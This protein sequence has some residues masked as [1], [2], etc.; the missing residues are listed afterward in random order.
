MN[1]GTG[2]DRFCP[3]S[4]PW[5]ILFAMIAPLLLGLA[6]PGLVRARG[7]VPVAR[8][9]LKKIMTVD[10]YERA[11]LNRL[12]AVQRR[13]FEA[14]LAKH[15]QEMS[16]LIHPARVSPAP[17]GHQST[18]PSAP[19]RFGLPRH[20]RP[21]ISGNSMES[22]IEGIFRGWS[23]ATRF[24][25]ANGQ[26]WAQTDSGYF[27]ISPVLNPRV[28]IKKLLVGYVLRVRGYG[29]QVFVTRVH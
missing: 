5:R 20:R 23:G 1:Q 8:V 12:T 2:R 4:R 6:L 22:R 28:K 17:R 3:G 29:E 11:G 7:H 13:D 18:Q 14:W 16:N 26:T 10:A 15:L 25:L 24:H 9:P 21:L 27:R 19:A